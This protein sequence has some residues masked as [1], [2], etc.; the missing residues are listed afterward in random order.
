MFKQFNMQDNMR[1]ISEI[2]KIDLKFGE[3]NEIKYQLPETECPKCHAHIDAVEMSPIDLL[4]M[5]AQLLITLYSTQG[6]Q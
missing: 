1:L 5:R 2:G 3:T 4:F 6:L